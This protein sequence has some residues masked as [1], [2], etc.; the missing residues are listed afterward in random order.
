MKK[1][2]VAGVVVC[3]LVLLC[4]GQAAAQPKNLRTKRIRTPK[5]QTQQSAVLDK[6][7]L[8][9]PDLIVSKFEVCKRFDRNN[10]AT[11]SV[12]FKNIGEGRASCFDWV[13]TDSKGGASVKSVCAQDSGSWFLQPG[14]EKTITGTIRKSDVWSYA[15]KPGYISHFRI[16]VNKGSKEPKVNETTEVNNGSDEVDIYWDATGVAN[17]QCTPFE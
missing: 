11:Y 9:S 15:Y 12:T 10:L 4:V 8:E 5:I 1:M 3:V 7:L 2:V 17:H 14:A 13:L 16:R 6:S